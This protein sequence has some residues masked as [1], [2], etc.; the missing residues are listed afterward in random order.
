[1]NAAK[2]RLEPGTRVRFCGDAYKVI[3]RNGNTIC[4]RSLDFQDT[5]QFW[6]TTD[7]VH[8]ERQGKTA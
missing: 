4:I 3:N 8:R 6:T 1:M 5:Q 7:K 2:T